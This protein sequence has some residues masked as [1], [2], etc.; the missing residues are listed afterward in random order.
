[1]CT[2][3]IRLFALGIVYL[4]RKALTAQLSLRDDLIRQPDK[5][6]YERAAGEWD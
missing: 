3:H 1:M 2:K 4:N 6:L 5:K